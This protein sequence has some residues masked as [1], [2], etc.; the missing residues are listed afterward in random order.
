MQ[1][2]PIP[3]L[4][5]LPTRISP[6]PI[7][8][9][10]LEVRFVT[11]KSWTLMPGQFFSEISDRYMEPELLPLGHLPDEL[12]KTEKKWTYKP[13]VRFAGEPFAIQFGPR[14]VSLIANGEY[15]G[16]SAVREE[17]SWL[18]DRLKATK[19]VA[20][21]ER[22]GMR[23]IDFF[24]GN[25]FPNLM[26]ETRSAGELVGAAEMSLTTV[27]QREEFRARLLLNNSVFVERGGEAQAGSV[28]DLDLFLS[29]SKFELFE[30]GMDKFEVAHRLNKEVFFGLLK[31]D[32]LDTLA[33][34]Y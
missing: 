3:A 25:I 10:I 32:F 8:E 33:P 21:G 16:W 14:M 11:R 1:D 31:P 26:V 27:F 17:M 20:E 13:L 23:Y 29:A 9:A 7:V 24:P 34:E 5:R 2:F 28:L 15:P 18:L 19:I 4:D 6:C 22:L 30:D 12:R